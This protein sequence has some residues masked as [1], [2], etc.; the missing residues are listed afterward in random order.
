MKASKY[1]DR[2]KLVQ[3]IIKNEYGFWKWSGGQWRRF[4]SG[5]WYWMTDTKW[6]E[7]SWLEILLATGMSKEYLSITLKVQWGRE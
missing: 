1:T 3:Y 6:T 2:S 5:D 4:V 7:C